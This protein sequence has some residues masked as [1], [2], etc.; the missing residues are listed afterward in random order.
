MRGILQD[1]TN[2]HPDKTESTGIG[3]LRM[4]KENITSSFQRRVSE[5]QK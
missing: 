3:K 4:N 1:S 2:V 5:S